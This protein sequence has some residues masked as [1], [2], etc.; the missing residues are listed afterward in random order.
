M[1]T[2]IALAISA[3]F[4]SSALAQGLADARR[5]FLEDFAQAIAG[6]QVC[7]RYA[8]NQ[9]MAAFVAVRFKVVFNNPVV[10][11]HIEERT[12]FHRQRIEGRSEEDICGALLRLYGPEGSNTKNLI[13]SK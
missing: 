8:L 7:P 11:Q 5:Q 13:R 4:V 10:Q 6:T 1:R 3:T 12:R 9:P 2:L